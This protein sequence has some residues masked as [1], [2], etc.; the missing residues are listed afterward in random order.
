M[1]VWDAIFDKLSLFDLARAQYVCRLWRHLATVHVEARAK[2]C[3]LAGCGRLVLE[4]SKEQRSRA[5]TTYRN[6]S[7]FKIFFLQQSPLFAEHGRIVFNVSAR[8]Q[9]TLPFHYLGDVGFAHLMYPDLRN[10]SYS[11]HQVYCVDKFP[12]S[13]KIRVP[14][15]WSAYKLSRLRFTGIRVLA[16]PPKTFMRD[17]TL[18]GMFSKAAALPVADGRGF[19][20]TVAMFNDRRRRGWW[21]PWLVQLVPKN[22]PTNTLGEAEMLRNLKLSRREMGELKKWSEEWASAYINL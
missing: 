8:Y 22:N 17:I 16:S 21:D 12:E 19:D 18:F 15:E 4:K 3:H 5:L 2:A 6:Y 13:T 11:F 1:E 20:M 14:T 9:G 10:P 7:P